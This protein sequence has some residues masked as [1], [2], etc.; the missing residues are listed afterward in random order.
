MRYILGCSERQNWISRPLSIR[1]L[2]APKRELLPRDLLILLELCTL[3]KSR[4]S[5]RHGDI[6]VK[7]PMFFFTNVVTEMKSLIKSMD[8]IPECDSLWEVF[9]ESNKH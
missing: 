8:V 4:M 9:V 6:D 1:F 7:S 3:R 2:P 5:V